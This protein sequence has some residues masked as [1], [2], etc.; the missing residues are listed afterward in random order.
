[1]LWWWKARWRFELA[2]CVGRFPGTVHGVWSPQCIWTAIHRT[3]GGIWREQSINRYEYNV[4]FFFSV[5]LF[6]L[7]VCSSK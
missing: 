4:E 5:A 1:M 7:E 3:A 2:D 6:A